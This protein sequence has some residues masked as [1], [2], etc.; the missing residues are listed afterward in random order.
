VT[1][2][3]FAA[4]DQDLEVTATLDYALWK[5]VVSRVEYRWDHDLKDANHFGSGKRD[6]DHLIALNVIYKF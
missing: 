2:P 1:A 4:G 6:N 5:D 3:G